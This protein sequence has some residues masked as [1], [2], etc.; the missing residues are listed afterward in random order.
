M[1][2]SEE[3]LIGLQRL[4]RQEKINFFLVYS[5]DLKVF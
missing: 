3:F 4:G 5:R 1:A 2:H